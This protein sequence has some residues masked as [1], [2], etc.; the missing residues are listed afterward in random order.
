[1]PSGAQAAAHCPLDA[2]DLISQLHHM[3]KEVT[4]GPGL[5]RVW[6]AQCTAGEVLR[7][8]PEHPE[9][10]SVRINPSGLGLG[11]R[12]IRLHRH[13]GGDPEKDSLQRE[14]WVRPMNLP[15]GNGVPEPPDPRA[16]DG[17]WAPARTG[18]G[19]QGCG[20]SLG[21]RRKGSA[22]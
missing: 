17:G 10:A 19:A 13:K 3:H 7:G 18:L 12:F 8:H 15:P 16:H 20:L 9:S 6:D 22:S 14:A 1:M 11:T 5:P 2:G 21:T 4:L